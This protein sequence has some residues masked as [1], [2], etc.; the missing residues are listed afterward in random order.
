MTDALFSIK[1]R[2]VHTA[3]NFHYYANQCFTMSN[4]IYASKGVTI[5]LYYDYVKI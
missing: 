5:V 4:Y 1:S 3:V 2:G